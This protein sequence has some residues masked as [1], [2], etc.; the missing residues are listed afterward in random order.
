MRSTF[1]C[2]SMMLALL[3]AQSTRAAAQLASGA[4]TSA[5]PTSTNPQI[6]QMQITFDPD[7]VPLSQ[8]AHPNVGG[9][10]AVSSYDLSVQ[11]DPNLVSESAVDFVAPYT[12]TTD[13]Q[14]DPAG[15][16]LNGVAGS[17]PFD[18]VAG[19]AGK[20]VNIFIVTFTL[21][22]GVDFN[23]PMSFTIFGRPNV[24]FITGVDPSDNSTLTSQNTA[25]DPNAI[26]PTTINLTY[27][28]MIDATTPEPASLALLGFAIPLLTRRRLKKI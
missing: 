2:I 10:Y 23:T 4:K 5:Q 11:Y 17:A 15:G 27:Q 25:Q 22:P 26:E 9:P 13:F 12:M 7:I 21:N 28:Q 24:D 16:F 3:F 18:E 19:T 20:D 6:R 1:F 14:N 8:N